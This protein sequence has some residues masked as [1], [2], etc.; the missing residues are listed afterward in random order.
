M[1]IHLSWWL[2]KTCNASIYSGNDPKLQTQYTK[3]ITQSHIQSNAHLHSNQT[4]GRLILN[5]LLLVRVEEKNEKKSF[6]CVKV[7]TI[8]KFIIHTDRG[9]ALR[10]CLMDTVVK[11]RRKSKVDL[12]SSQR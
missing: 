10:L 4:F 3:L 11:K 12:I 1:K 6:T 5:T 9:S 2:S 7:T 8:I